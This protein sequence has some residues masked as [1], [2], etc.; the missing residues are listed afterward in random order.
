MDEET[1]GQKKEGN[2]VEMISHKKERQYM[3]MKT[4]KKNKMR[5]GR[6][7]KLL[8]FSLTSPLCL[9]FNQLVSFLNRIL[10]ASCKPYI[11]RQLS[12]PNTNLKEY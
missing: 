11:G 9:A 3:M 7:C 6:D 12:V 2:R 10:P 5:K 1:I 8:S 4:K